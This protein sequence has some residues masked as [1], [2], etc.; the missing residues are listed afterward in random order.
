MHI[1]L[2]VARALPCSST[3]HILLYSPASPVSAH[4]EAQKQFRGGIGDG[5]VIRCSEC[6][7]EILL[8]IP[9]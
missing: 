3:D 2:P 4:L 1:G 9:I 5:R 8:D 7:E 6:P